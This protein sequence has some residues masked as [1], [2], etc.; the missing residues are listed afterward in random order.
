[1]YDTCAKQGEIYFLRKLLF[2]K[3]GAISRSVINHSTL[4]EAYCAIISL[5][6]DAQ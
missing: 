4:R 5:S 3:S 6:D 2:N 1:M